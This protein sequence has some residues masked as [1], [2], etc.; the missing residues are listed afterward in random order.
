MGEGLWSDPACD[1]RGPAWGGAGLRGYGWP[2]L[3][4][5]ASRSARSGQRP[6]LQQALNQLCRDGYPDIVLDLSGLEFLG[7]AGLT[8]FHQVHD[9]LR[10]VNG[11]LILH[12]PRRLARHMLAV[13][14]LDTVLTIQ[15]AT[16][17]ASPATTSTVAPPSSLTQAAGNEPSC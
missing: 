1:Q 5:E 7:A 2:P 14:G 10:G 6:H 15:P 3:L 12:R 9:Q 4:G 17:A 8:V 16:C 11:R 13:T